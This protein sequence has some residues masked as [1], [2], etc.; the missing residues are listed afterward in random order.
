VIEEGRDDTRIL[1][2]DDDPMIC[3]LLALGLEM[4]GY[5]CQTLSNPASVLEAIGSQ[6][7]AVVLLDFHLG[8]EAGLDLLQSIRSHP[9]CVGLPVVLMSALDYQEESRRAG[10]DGFVLKPFSF[11]ELLATIRAVLNT[12]SRGRLR[13]SA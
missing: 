6:S 4:E 1:I 5:A 8:E 9:A 2:V 13:R 7:P 12:H 3:Q 11:E 10:A